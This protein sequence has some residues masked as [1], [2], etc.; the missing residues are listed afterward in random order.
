MNGVTTIN[1]A[2]N[3]V[4]E[5]F[6]QQLQRSREEG[7]QANSACRGDV[8]ANVAFS[9]LLDLDTQRNV[10]LKL[11]RNRAF[12]PRIRSLIGTPPYSFLRPGDEHILNA[13]GIAQ[14]RARMA[15][16][17]KMAVLNVNEIGE[18]HFSDS[19]GRVFKVVLVDNKNRFDSD[20]DPVPHRSLSP[21]LRVVLDMRL[22]KKK[23]SERVEIIKR[24]STLEK[25]S[26]LFPNVGEKL[27]LVLQEKLQY[28]GTKSTVSV[29]IKS[30]LQRSVSSPVVRLFC[31]VE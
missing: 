31:I 27:M 28:D 29:T 19:H 17:D 4:N 5:R 24:G 20:G 21:G 7:I 25:K 3:F 8:D 12:W 22:A 26:V 30:R 1:D 23:K 14:G 6:V 18:G 16:A 13:S 11:C 10:F 15:Y 2:V 9:L